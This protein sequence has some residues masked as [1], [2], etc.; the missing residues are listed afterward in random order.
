V[1]L[2]ALKVAAPPRWEAPS[3]SGQRE[4]RAAGGD[5]RRSRGAVVRG[6]FFFGCV[7]GGG[8][9]DEKKTDE[10][11]GTK[12]TME[13]ILPTETLGVEICYRCFSGSMY[14]SAALGLLLVYVTNVLGHGPA[15]VLRR[16]IRKKIATCTKD[17][18]HH[19]LF[20]SFRLQPAKLA[21][22][23]VNYTAHYAFK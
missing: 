12:K 20:A 10:S 15:L 11:G 14:A 6:G 4:A 23:Y 3:R 18:T 9:G 5:G 17:R 2:P 8:G 19:L 1:A 13:T 7:R 21:P 16:R 22:V